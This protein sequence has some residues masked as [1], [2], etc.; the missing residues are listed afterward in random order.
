LASNGDG[1]WTYTPETGFYGADSFIYAVSDGNGGTATATVDITVLKAVGP[2]KYTG[3][4]GAIK[5]NGTT[6][7]NLGI[8][9]VGTISSVSVQIDVTHQRMSDL[10]FALIAPDGTRIALTLDSYGVASGDFSSLSGKQFNGT[11]Q[12]EIKDSKR[13]NTGTLFDWSLFLE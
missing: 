10:S 7:Y 8:S 4:G 3:T 11:W 13:R 1:T 12:L 6:V 9:D 2:T 5:D